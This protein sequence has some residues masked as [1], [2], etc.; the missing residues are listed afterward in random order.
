M[1]LVVWRKEKEFQGWGCEDCEFLLQQPR[2]G[3][4]LGEYVATIRNVFDAHNCE[5]LQ[6]P[7]QGRVPGLGLVKKAQNGR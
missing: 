4:S 5:A 2:I 1:S 3:E 7:W 6:Q